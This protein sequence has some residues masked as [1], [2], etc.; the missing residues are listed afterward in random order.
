LTERFDDSVALF[1]ERFGLVLPQYS[2]SNASPPHGDDDLR[3]D[4]FRAEARRRN[5]L[6]RELY[7]YAVELFDARVSAYKER[8]LNLSMQPST[9]EGVLSFARQRALGS[10]RLPAK[11]TSVSLRGW[12][13]VD[14]APPDAVLVRVD[15]QVIPVVGRIVN[16][17]AARESSSSVNRYSGIAGVVPTPP[18]TET[19]SVIA[20][21][22]TRGLR[23][24]RKMVIERDPRTDPTRGTNSVGARVVRA[25]RRRLRR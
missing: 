11:A 8:L 12:L 13:L 23:G 3:S 18:G 6:D 4:E 25:A 16:A 5:E 14:G 19:V 1:A 17:E 21:D 10:V 20:L 2:I 9:L 15:D 24:E 7:A 22:R